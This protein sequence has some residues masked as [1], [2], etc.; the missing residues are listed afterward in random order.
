MNNTIKRIIT[1]ILTAL[2]CISAS[3]EMDEKNTL[4]NLFTFNICINP[5]IAEQENFDKSQLIFVTP[6]ENDAYRARVLSYARAGDFTETINGLKITVL[7]KLAVN[8]LCA[9]EWTIENVSGEPRYIEPGMMTVNGQV[10]AYSGS[11]SLGSV[12]L[13]GE[14][15]QFVAATMLPELEG[16]SCEAAIPCGEYRIAAEAIAA[17]E[18]KE[19]TPDEDQIEPIGEALFTVTI[20]RDTE[21]VLRAQQDVN[22]QIKWRDS[23]LAVEEAWQSISNGSYTVLRIFDT[24]EQAAA[25]NPC[26]DETGWDFELYCDQEENGGMWISI[27]GGVLDDIPFELDD[28]RWAYALN[29]TAE[30]LNWLPENGTVYVVPRTMGEDGMLIEDWTAAIKL[31][32][33]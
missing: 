31:Q 7:R 12:L 23:M 19:W 21:P 18:D 3:A 5:E 25:N 27:G 28:G 17:A 33:Q 24:Y 15:R 26:D 10:G 30:M 1:L 13:P 20:A 11:S 14:R 4:E 8:S 2:L 16:E 29:K 9:M 6:P 22:A 32:L